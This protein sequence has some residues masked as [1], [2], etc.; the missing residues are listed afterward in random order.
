MGCSRWAYEA[1]RCDGDYCPGDCD[2]CAKAAEYG[3]RTALESME[4]EDLREWVERVSEATETP[5][6]TVMMLYEGKKDYI[7]MTEQR[8]REWV[9]DWITLYKRG[10]K[11]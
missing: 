4:Q 5:T 10:F 6:E 11:S 9:E 2:R 7:S 3:I 8:R 1:D